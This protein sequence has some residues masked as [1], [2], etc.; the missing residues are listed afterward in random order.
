VYSFGVIIWELLS[1]KIPYEGMSEAQITG[2]VGYDETHK[3]PDIPANSD[4]FII[5]IM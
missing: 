5:S 3:L 2:N 1:E 4:K